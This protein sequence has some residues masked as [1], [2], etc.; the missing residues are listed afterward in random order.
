MLVITAV[1]QA[2]AY[3]QSPGFLVMW[4]MDWAGHTVWYQDVSTPQLKHF[5]NISWYI[6][7]VVAPVTAV[8]IIMEGEQAFV[9]HPLFNDLVT[10]SCEIILL[11]FATTAYVGNITSKSSSDKVGW[12]YLTILVAII[13]IASS[14][15][16][17]RTGTA[18]WELRTWRL[19]RY[20][21]EES[22][23]SLTD[24]GSHDPLLQAYDDQEGARSPVLVGQSE[25]SFFCRR[26]LMSKQPYR[27]D[28][29][30]ETRQSEEAGILI[31]EIVDSTRQQL[32]SGGLGFEHPP[33]PRL[34]WQMLAAGT[35]TDDTHHF[36]LAGISLLTLASIIDFV[37]AIVDLVLP[38]HFTYT[39]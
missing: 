31:P 29:R 28:E 15:F 25:E 22:G 13:W 10:T 33:P 26:M 5:L 6:S 35:D 7:I 39:W 38:K 2:T 23:M 32:A 21:E 9:G 30:P 24:G 14:S 17:L 18:Y 19:A 12:V 37:C 4:I 34:R 20:E 8:R 3:V 11:S 1:I 27:D 36:P 16:I